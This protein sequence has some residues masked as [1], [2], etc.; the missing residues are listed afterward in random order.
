MVA[1]VLVLPDDEPAAVADDRA[2]SENENKSSESH[3]GQVNSIESIIK[4]MQIN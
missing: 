4:V 3:D 1:I 2:G